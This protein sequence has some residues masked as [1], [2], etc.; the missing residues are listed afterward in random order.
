[1][2]KE[3]SKVV[4]WWNT[5][6]GIQSAR[7][8]V[9]ADSANEVESVEICLVDSCLLMGITSRFVAYDET[10]HYRNVTSDGRL[11]SDINDRTGW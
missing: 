10:R 9:T 2:P 5:G 4:P 8:V 3:G 7:T 6:A 11:L 1:M